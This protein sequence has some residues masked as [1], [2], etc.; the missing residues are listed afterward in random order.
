MSLDYLLNYV[1]KQLE[2]IKKSIADLE[3]MIR[4]G[5]LMG[6]DVSQQRIALEQLK[7]RA[8]QYED[9]LQ[10]FKASRAVKPK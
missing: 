4:L 3:E 1:E 7:A 9:G 10:K 8:K 6:I 5:E 2:E